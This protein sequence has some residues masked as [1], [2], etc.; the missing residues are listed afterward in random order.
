[1]G[2]AWEAGGASSPRAGDVRAVWALV[3]VRETQARAGDVRAA[4]PPRG[5]AKQ[6]RENELQPRASVQMSGR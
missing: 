2:C 5:R 4:W 6:G 1:M 3:W